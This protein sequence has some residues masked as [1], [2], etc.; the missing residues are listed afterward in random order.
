[1]FYRNGEKVCTYNKPSVPPAM[2]K[3]KDGKLYDKYG[4]YNSYVSR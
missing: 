1:M 2:A 3:V 4:I